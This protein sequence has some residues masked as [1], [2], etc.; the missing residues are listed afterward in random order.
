MLY[1]FIVQIANVAGVSIANMDPCRRGAVW[2]DSTDPDDLSRSL[3]LARCVCS[4]WASQAEHHR[5]T[6]A[7][8]SAGFLS[9]PDRQ[10]RQSSLSHT[11]HGLCLHV[12]NVAMGKREEF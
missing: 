1:I 2:P 8:G 9:R 6:I 10:S 4:E 3:S 7:S 12:S 11:Q 5:H